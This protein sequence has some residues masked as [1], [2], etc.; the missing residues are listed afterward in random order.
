MRS[1]ITDNSDRSDMTDRSVATD[2]AGAAVRNHEGE[3]Q[4]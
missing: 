3:G 2:R 1:I 4:P